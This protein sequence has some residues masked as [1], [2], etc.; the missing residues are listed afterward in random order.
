MEK[1]NLSD[2]AWSYACEILEHLWLLEKRGKFSSLI[3]LQSFFN[4]T[5]TYTRTTIHFLENFG[6]ISIENKSIK[7][8]K[9]TYKKLNGSRDKSVAVLKEKI[10]NFKPY[11]EYYYFLSA[12]KTT[13]YSAKYIKLLYNIKQD[14]DRITRIFNKWSKFFNIKQE[15]KTIEPSTDLTKLNKALENELLLN[16]FLREQ[17]GGHYKDIGDNIVKDLIKALRNYK[18]DP[19]KSVNDS[20]RALEDFLRLDFVESIDLTKCSGI[21]QI[22]Q[23]LNRY[24]ISSKKHNGIIAGL[25][26]IRSMGDAHGADKNENE[27]ESRLDKRRYGDC[28]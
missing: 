12:G 18:T 9:D 7:L 23:T 15:S 13:D 19:N 2:V 8:K 11:V 22:S 25:G 17:F 26:N 21:G 28:C 5:P 10:I 1:I 4:K 6:L 20:G 16:A 3:E 14:A 24:N 27:R